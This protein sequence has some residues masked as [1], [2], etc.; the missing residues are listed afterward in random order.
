MKKKIL[1][2]F[3]ILFLM[4]FLTGCSDNSEE[5]NLI[6]KTYSEI[7]YLD[8]KIIKMSNN[9]NN[10]S[11]GDNIDLSKSINWKVLNSDLEEI[12]RSWNIIIIDLYKLKVNNDDILNFSSSLDKLSIYIKEEN[13]NS[14]LL[15]LANMYSYILKYSEKI[16]TNEIV[17]NIKKLKEHMLKAYSSVES[18][19]WDN[20]NEEILLADSVFKNI[21]NDLEYITQ[22]GDNVNRTYVALQELKN[23]LQLEDVNIFYI[24][25]R[26]LIHEISF[27]SI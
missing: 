2:I 9:I 18:L 21:N 5:T 1:Y 20:V 14:T 3:L 22:N 17:K 8:N 27:L 19:N 23:S 11:F 24:K 7:E 4:F 26:N 25:Y 10:I 12:Y 13:K 15:E 16:H 6:E